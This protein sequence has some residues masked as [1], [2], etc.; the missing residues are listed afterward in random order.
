[1]EKSEVELI[2]K[3]LLAF[4]SSEDQ[5]L[6]DSDDLIASGVLDSLTFMKLLIVMEQKLN[7]HFERNELKMENFRSID[8]IIRLVAKKRAPSPQ[9]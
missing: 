1:M 8:A 7:V 5:V 6:T 3:E 9:V 2:R 4:T